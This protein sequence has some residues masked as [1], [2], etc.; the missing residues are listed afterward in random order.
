ML[1]CPVLLI[2]LQKGQ[3]QWSV[4]T[5]GG[6]PQMHKFPSPSRQICVFSPLEICLSKSIAHKMYL[7]Y[8][9]AGNFK[10]QINDILFVKYNFSLFLPMEKH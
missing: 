5:A 2:T 10:G 7:D 8:Q 9:P 3:M 4:V 1:L 6:I